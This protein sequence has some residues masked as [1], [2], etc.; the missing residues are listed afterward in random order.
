MSPG[1]GTSTG[2][3]SEPLGTLSLSPHGGGRSR[4]PHGARGA[5]RGDIHRA[6]PTC[7]APRPARHQEPGR[8]QAEAGGDLEGEGGGESER[9]LPY[10]CASGSPWG[11]GR[12]TRG[13]RAVPRLA[14]EGARAGDSAQAPPPEGVGTRRRSSLLAGRAAA[15]GE[16]GAAGA[17]EPCVPG[18][19]AERPQP[20]PAAPHP[21]RGAAQ[22][23]GDVLLLGLP[24]RPP[25]PRWPGGISPLPAVLPAD[26]SFLRSAVAAAA[27]R[28]PPAPTRARRAEP[29]RS[30]G[31][32][33][34]GGGGHAVRVGGGGGRVPAV[35]G[36]GGGEDDAVRVRAA[37]VPL[38]RAL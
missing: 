22:S 35:A 34:G 21:P 17:A 11:A 37:A 16:G 38:R 30:G 15:R 18:A 10:A 32:R 24:L 27:R 26:G 13:T 23:P 8:G 31:G 7:L 12:G 33:A 3:Q 29:L 1:T 2:E 36:G 28:R 20:P 9:C 6:P 14:G 25:P 19:A 4:T 5:G